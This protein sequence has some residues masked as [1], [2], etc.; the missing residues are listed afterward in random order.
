MKMVQ[1]VK[2]R[3]NT[4]LIKNSMVQS[5]I[6]HASSKYR[7]VPPF[8]E[9]LLIGIDEKLRGPG[10]F[11]ML[12]GKQLDPWV[13]ILFFSTTNYQDYGYNIK[14]KR[15]SCGINPFPDGSKTK[16]NLAIQQAYSD[17]MVD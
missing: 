17:A 6:R 7:G 9:M 11:Y 13:N 16:Y 15:W 2:Q 3:L 4:T 10:Q 1:I 12:V 5:F 14:E 8:D